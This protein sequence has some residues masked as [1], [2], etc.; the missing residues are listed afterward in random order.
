MIDQSICFMSMEEMLDLDEGKKRYKGS[1][2][3][4]FLLCLADHDFNVKINWQGCLSV[5]SSPVSRLEMD[6]MSGRILFP[7]SSVGVGGRVKLKGKLGSV[8]SEYDSFWEPSID[9]QIP[10]PIAYSIEML[11][12]VEPSS[13]IREEDMRELK[14]NYLLPTLHM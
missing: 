11:F 5:D 8:I 2:P 3:W 9:M 4:I 1:S 14:E 6:D 10:E 13:L 7:L 12:K